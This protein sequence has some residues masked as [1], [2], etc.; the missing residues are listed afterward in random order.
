MV[1]QSRTSAPTNRLSVI[2]LRNCG[3]HRRFI[4][5]R[6]ERQRVQPRDRQRRALP[7]APLGSPPASPRSFV[8]RLQLIEAYK[9]QRGKLGFA[10]P[11][12]SGP[13]VLPAQLGRSFEKLEQSGA[14]GL[15]QASI[16]HATCVAIRLSI[17]WQLPT[18]VLRARYLLW[19]RAQLG[20]LE[21]A[22]QCG[23]VGHHLNACCSVSVG[24]RVVL[25]EPLT[26][27]ASPPCID[28]SAMTK[29]KRDP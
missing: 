18:G 12:P 23:L 8:R 22:R 13:P 16:K 4:S 1:S 7:I 29:Q 6:G 17:Q 20:C 5:G 24:M 25:A 21:L 26:S 3:G 9:E 10:I 11:E 19:S 14:N 28:R 15:K 2:C 27:P